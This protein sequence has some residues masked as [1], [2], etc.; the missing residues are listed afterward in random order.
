MFNANLT[1]SPFSLCEST[2]VLLLSRLNEVNRV[3][4]GC[5][6][7]ELWTILLW[8]DTVYTSIEIITMHLTILSLNMWKA[9]SSCP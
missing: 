8:C 7:G 6:G 2:S 5:H 4:L 3:T 1:Y 9:T